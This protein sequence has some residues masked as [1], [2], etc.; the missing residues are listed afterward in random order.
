MQCLDKQM[1]EENQKPN[2]GFQVISTSDYK[3]SGDGITWPR[4][5]KPEL[6]RPIL[7]M[8][9]HGESQQLPEILSAAERR[10]R[11]ILPLFPFSYSPISH[12]ACL[13][14]SPA[15]G[16]LNRGRLGT[17]V[18]AGQTPATEKGATQCEDWTWGAASLGPARSSSLVQEGN[19][20]FSFFMFHL[21]YVSKLSLSGLK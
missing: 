9:S 15:R 19:G 1:M 6:Y 13:W 21:P 20:I 2:R 3:D 5:Q 8:C 18:F 7:G 12:N 16:Q 4:G 14:L 10:E 17:K 11:K